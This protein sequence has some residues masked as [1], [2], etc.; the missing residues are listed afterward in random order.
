MMTALI[1]EQS[2]PNPDITT[3]PDSVTRPLRAL[4][5]KSEA[6]VIPGTLKLRFLVISYSPQRIVLNVTL[7]STTTKIT[8]PTSCFPLSNYVFI[9]GSKGVLDI[10]LIQHN[11]LEPKSITGVQTTG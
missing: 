3:L 8:F 5:R 6:P 2:R 4:I 11:G 10:E 7:G 1:R 9:K